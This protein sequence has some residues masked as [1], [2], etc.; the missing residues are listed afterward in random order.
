MQEMATAFDVNINAVRDHILALVNKGFLKQVPG[1]K[2]YQRTIKFKQYM[3][4]WPKG[5]AA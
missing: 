2:C 4:S 5:E 1:R 3:A